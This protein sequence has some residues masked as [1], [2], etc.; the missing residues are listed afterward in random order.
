MASSSANKNMVIINDEVTSFT[1]YFEE[2][3]MEAWYHMQENV[4]NISNVHTQSS[5]IKSFYNG[6][7]AWG[8]IFLDGLTNGH[9]VTGDPSFAKYT[10]VSL[11]GNYGKTKEDIK[12][13]QFKE[14]LEEVANKLQEAIKKAPNREEISNLCN[15]TRSKLK[16][17]NKSFNN[18]GKKIRAVE[19]RAKVKERLIE[20]VNKKIFFMGKFLGRAGDVFKYEDFSKEFTIVMEGK[21]VEEVKMLSDNVNE[22]LLNLDKC[23]LNELINILQNFANDLP[24][25]V[26]QIGFGSYIA[27]HVIM[28]KIQRYSNEPMIPPKLGDVWIPKILIVVGKES[29]NV[30]ALGQGVPAPVTRPGPRGERIRTHR[31]A[32]GPRHC[33]PVDHRF[34]GAKSHPQAHLREEDKDSCYP[35]YK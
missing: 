21:E 2:S 30:G 20:N 22:P 17:Y 7:S 12:L 5:I 24:F 4:G 8:R 10:L 23:S 35:G 6:V 1:Q 18:F 29:H 33:R 13:Q 31:A 25:N 34:P 3:L 28:E 19:Y 26:H 11:F 32:A 9:F 14:E 27:N 16:N 15:Y